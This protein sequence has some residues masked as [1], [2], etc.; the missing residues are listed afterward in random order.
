MFTRRQAIR[1][2][3]LWLSCWNDRDFDTLL[4]MH[5]DDTR[6]GVWSAG[7]EGPRL[8][9]K[10]AMKRHWAALPFGLHSVPAEL[11]EVAWDPESREITVV[12]VADF[13]FSRVR[14]CDLVSLDATGRII[15]GEPCVGSIVEEPRPA[16]QQQTREW[17]LSEGAGGR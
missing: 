4:A 6:F 1:W 12:Y 9:R 17:I 5:R 16:S 8:D 10:E 11:D 2:A 15:A 3:E 7:A 13:D 14:G